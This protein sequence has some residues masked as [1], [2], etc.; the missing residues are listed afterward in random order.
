[1]SRRPIKIFL[2]SPSKDTQAARQLVAR[3]ALEVAEEAAYREMFDV[4][5]CRWDDPLH[6]V[7]VSAAHNPQQDIVEQVADPKKCD[8]VIALFRHTMGGRLEEQRCG[9]SPLGQPWHCT[10]WEVAQGL[11]GKQVGDVRDVW[12]FRDEEEFRAPITLTREQKKAADEEYDAVQAYFEW[13]NP[14]G[15]PMRAGVNVYRSEGTPCITDAIK[16]RLRTWLSK[17]ANEGSFGEKG[18]AAP[19][20]PGSE[21][22]AQSSRDPAESVREFL[23]GDPIA[24]ARAFGELASAGASGED[25]LFAQPI[26]IAS[27]QVR[28]R[29]LRYVASRPQTTSARLLERVRGPAEDCYAAAELFAGL[30]EPAPMARAIQTDLDAAFKDHT[31]DLAANESYWRVAAL[32]SAWGAVG[33]T[34][35]MPWQLVVR[36]RYAWE[37]LRVHAFRAACAAAA[38]TG[39]QHLGALAKMVSHHWPQYER[40]S[41]IAAA[42]DDRLDASAI[43][44]PELWLQSFYTFPL[45]RSGDVVDGVLED[46]SR[47]EHWRVRALGAEVLEGIGFRRAATPVLDWLRRESVASVREGL[48]GALGRSNTKVGADALLAI[49]QQPVSGDGAMASRLRSA[50]AEAAW[51]A[52]DKAAAVKALEPIA[53]GDDAVA[54]E[55]LVALA[56]LG[57][58]PRSLDD[59]L[60]S[61]DRYRRTNAA[62][63]VG[64]LGERRMTDEL[65]AMRAETSGLLE[66]VY[67]AAALALLGYPGASNDLHQRL[68]VLAESEGAG[69]SYDIFRMKRPL[70]QAVIDAFNSNGPASQPFARAWQLEIEPLDAVARPADLARR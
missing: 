25:A 24:G 30:P 65:L 51:R 8:L 45:W 67:V 54:S 32:L 59:A 68:V 23:G 53:D 62:L 61:I 58:R 34:S 21:S 57:T 13:L 63:A 5:L 20:A 40:L 43:D 16:A 36:D 15:E 50:L 7:A 17:L 70:Q 33:G 46:W 48:I 42:T 35:W 55:A 29:W 11:V 1:M 64:Y 14:P 12:I 44:G 26:R 3:A 19:A 2:A 66:P 27:V 56:R 39:R 22:R 47:H 69:E 37:K 6:P 41:L 38:R 52:S 4:R 60:V 9:L 31:P 18:P 10:E 49:A 28:R